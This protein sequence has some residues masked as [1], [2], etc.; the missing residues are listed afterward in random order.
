MRGTL[1]EGAATEEIP[2]MISRS[3][4]DRL[5]ELTEDGRFNAFLMYEFLPHGKI[6]AVPPDETP[7][8]RRL[9]GNGLAAV[10][11]L[12]NTPENAKDALPGMRSVFK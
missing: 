12:D 11:W 10:Q 4:A 5:F 8:C 3:V 7:Y 6:N 2:Q 1:M 9:P